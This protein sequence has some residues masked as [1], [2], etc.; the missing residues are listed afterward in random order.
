MHAHVQWTQVSPHSVSC[1]NREHDT[2]CAKKASVRSLVTCLTCVDCF[3][4]CLDR[5]GTWERSQRKCS[6]YHSAGDTSRRSFLFLSMYLS[7]FL[8]SLW[9]YDSCCPSLSQSATL[10]SMCVHNLSV[11][12]DISL[13]PCVLKTCKVVCHEVVR[14][15]PRKLDFGMHTL[16]CFSGRRTEDRETETRKTIFADSYSRSGFHT[17]GLKNACFSLYV[18]KY[19][20]VLCMHTHESFALFENVLGS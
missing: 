5:F 20:T 3:C 19:L 2:W 17:F 16:I 8:Y 6:S 18:C 13:D 9:T 14:K 4:A 10:A 15:C 1:G 11:I 7:L 12:A